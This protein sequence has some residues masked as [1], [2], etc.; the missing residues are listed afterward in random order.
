MHELT[1]TREFD[2]DMRSKLHP[3]DAPNPIVWCER[4]QVHHR[5]HTFTQADYDRMLAEGAKRIQ[6]EID[7]Q[8]TEAIRSSLLVNREDNTR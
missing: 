8:V 7:K 4:C 2:D 6:A 5:L 3:A 1:V